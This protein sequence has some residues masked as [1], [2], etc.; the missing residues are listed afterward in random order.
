M[1]SDARRARAGRE[2]ERAD[3]RVRARVGREG[4]RP[5]FVVA[6][7]PGRAARDGRA[8]GPRGRGARDDRILG[9]RRQVQHRGGRRRDPGPQGPVGGEASGA[10]R[11]PLSCV[12][13]V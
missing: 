8:C 6:A 5:A 11:S 12:T 3:A 4:D 7:R 9:I 2:T 10:K 13:R 1:G